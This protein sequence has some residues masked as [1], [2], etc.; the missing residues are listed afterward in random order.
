MIFWH[1][2]VFSI[3]SNNEKKEILINNLLEESSDHKIWHISSEGLK[4]EDSIND[5]L[6]SEMENLIRGPVVERMEMVN[7]AIEIGNE[8]GE[9]QLDVLMRDPSPRV[10]RRIVYELVK[11]EPAISSA[12]E[13]F[14]VLSQDSD[15]EVR[16]IA[17]NQVGKLKDPI[18]VVI[19]NRMIEEE[20]DPLVRSGIVE[21][22]V[23]LGGE[24]GERL[25]DVLMKD[26]SPRVRSRIAFNLVNWWNVEPAISSAVERFKVLSQDSD[27]EV[28][29]AVTNQVGKLKDPISVV[30]LNRMIEEET[31]PLVRE[32]IVGGAI[33]LG[34][35]PGER[36]LDVLMNDPSPRVRYQI[37][38][39]LVNWNGE[40]AISSAVERFKVLSQDSDPEVR[41]AVANQVGKLKD[42]ISVVILNRMIEEETD[43]LVR[44]G[45][46]EG[47]VNLG[48]EPGERLLDVL[49]KDPSPRV[50]RQIAFELVNWNGKPAISSAVERFKVLSQD[51]DP[52]VRQI[53]ANRVGKLKDPISVVILNRMAK[54]E[55]ELKVQRAIKESAIE[56]GGVDGNRIVLEMLTQPSPS[57]DE[58]NSANKNNKRKSY[59]EENLLYVQMENV[60]ELIDVIGDENKNKKLRL[61][62]LRALKKLQKELSLK[63]IVQ[64]QKIIDRSATPWRIKRQLR[65]IV[66]RDK[67]E[68]ATLPAPCKTAFF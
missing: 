67:K 8:E 4:E 66:K 35:E 63:D 68:Q 21:G 18:S 58:R 6:T 61:R 7:K 12:V 39:E 45:I 33:H 13:R 48:G 53:A 23:N 43:P 57:T 30:I 52:E 17:A 15:P 31:D 16:Q 26:P 14:K 49:M 41:Q 34:G 19:L 46:V 40:P 44:S 55:T 59:Q 36:L 28:R 2:L 24:P 60:E 25:L 62:A 1:N 51:S 50:R 9:R 47:A 65:Q 3:D 64:I 54:R 37:A 5:Q 10:R 22:A 27:P 42:P 20:T 29:Q 32:G 11:G 38:F 56:I